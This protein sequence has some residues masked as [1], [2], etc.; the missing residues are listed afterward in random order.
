[1][2]VHATTSLAELLTFS[3][4]ADQGLSAYFRAHRE[5]GQQDR[6]FIAETVFAVLRRKRSLE[7]AAGSAV[8]RDLMIAALVRVFGLTRTTA[9]KYADGI[10]L[11]GE[12]RF[13]GKHTFTAWADPEPAAAEETLGD[14]STQTETITQQNES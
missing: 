12:Q 2:L 10:A 3:R 4:P 6:A 11:V 9:A 8:P 7:A 5:L 14:Y 1:M 13:H